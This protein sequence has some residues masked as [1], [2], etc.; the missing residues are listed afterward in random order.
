LVFLFTVMLFFSVPTIASYGIPVNGVHFPDFSDSTKNQSLLQCNGNAKINP[1]GLLPAGE[2]IGSWNYSYGS[3]Y[4][5][6]RLTLKEDRSFRTYFTFNGKRWQ[7]G[8]CFVLQQ[9]SKTALGGG[10]SMLGVVG[11]PHPL[12][13]VEIDTLKHGWWG[14]QEHVGL[15]I[16]PVGQDKYG[17]P[18]HVATSEFLTPL[19]IDLRS[20]RVFHV[21]IDYDGASKYFDV[22][23]NTC[24]DR[25][26]SILLIHHQV[27]LASI[28]DDTAYVGFTGAGGEPKIKSWTFWGNIDNFNPTLNFTKLPANLRVHK[29]ATLDFN[30]KATD[31]DPKDQNLEIEFYLDAGSGFHKVNNFTVNGTAYS[32]VL[33]A[34][35][36]TEYAIKINKTSLIPANVN[37]F[38]LKAVTKDSDDAQSEKIVTLT[39]YNNTP[40]IAFTSLPTNLKIHKLDQT[41]T[42][43]IQ[44]TDSD[45]TIDQNLITEIYIKGKKISDFSAKDTATGLSPTIS[46]GQISAVNGKEYQITVN[47][48]AIVSTTEDNFEL[49]VVTKDNCGAANNATVTITNYN[50]APSIT[51]SGLTADQKISKHDSTFS[52]SLTPSD[53]DTIDENLHVELYLVIEGKETRVNEFIAGGAEITDGNLP[54]KSNQTYN[55]IIDK[56]LPA[57]NP[58]LPNTVDKFTLKAVVRD[59]CQAQGTREIP[60][61]HDNA[62]PVVGITGLA[63][64]QRIRKSENILEFRLKVTDDDT[65]DANLETE[66][67]ILLLNSEQKVF[68]EQKVTEFTVNDVPYTQG[69]FIARSGEE[70]QITLNKGVY[71]PFYADRFILKAVATDTCGEKGEKE[72]SL[73]HYTDILAQWSLDSVKERIAVESSGNNNHG[74]IHGATLTTGIISNALEFDGTDDYINIPKSSFNNLPNWTFEA[75]VKP[76]GPGYIYSEGNPAATMV[77]EMKNDN[78]VNI[79]TWCHDRPGGAWNWFNTGANALTRDVWNHLVVTLENG[80]VGA[81]S[82]TVNCY[83]NGELFKSGGLGK[84]YNSATK[85]AALGGNIGVKANQG[86]NP[87]SG[88]IDEV[89][90]YGCALS[91]QEVKQNYQKVIFLENVKITNK[92]NEETTHPGTFGTHMNKIEFDLTKTVNELV[93]ELDLPSNIKVAH[94][95]KLFYD[96]NLIE[97]PMATA[98]NNKIILEQPFTAGHYKLEFILSIDDQLIVKTKSYHDEKRINTN[99]ESETFKFVFSD[100]ESLPGVL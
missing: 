34:R 17:T 85:E 46:N 48:N 56:S 93:L 51:I 49:K 80:D 10:G 33:S 42:F 1:D 71:V 84:E 68:S 76:V 100:L 28:I 74:V 99:H 59:G 15:L 52:F 23:I 32:G 45:T 25:S 53:S 88:C 14:H 86:L 75:W 77:I 27:D 69:K 78:S 19:G 11:V 30:I 16:N 98:D 35:N 67:Y 57:D 96:D 83:I 26:S 31:P 21:W 94:I 58:L 20:G 6:Y 4:T 54:A 41:L 24:N 89:T 9:D 40:A 29:A 12:V 81:G 7:D 64:D 90:L 38:R 39:H 50:T 18:A 66:F 92:H 63:N 95:E 62:V 65:A 36:G 82:G 73:I 91:A 87:F 22:R 8:M 55:I 47:K 61:I 44:A 13:A 70:Y 37:S 97:N 72:L 5:N 79:G 2:E 60:L 43:K 3:I